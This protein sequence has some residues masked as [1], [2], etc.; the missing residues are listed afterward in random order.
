MHVY[1]NEK[2]LTVTCSCQE[3]QNKEMDDD[4]DVYGLA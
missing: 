2:F 3:W 4:I 1:A